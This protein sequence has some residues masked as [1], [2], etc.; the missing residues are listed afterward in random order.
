MAELSLRNK[1]LHIARL[2]DL[3]VFQQKHLNIVAR[4]S[5]GFLFVSTPLRS[6]KIFGSRVPQERA[7][8]LLDSYI[9][10]YTAISQISYYSPLVFTR[11]PFLSVHW[12][13]SNWFVRQNYS[14]ISIKY[15]V[16]II[17][18]FYYFSANILFIGMTTRLTI[19]VL[20][21]TRWIHL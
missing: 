19:I 12:I 3:Q 11:M 10:I 7:K 14:K 9:S 21:Y 17:T 4:L 20:S 15:G 16:V 13:A 6:R 8:I 2:T 1:F 18:Y 5:T